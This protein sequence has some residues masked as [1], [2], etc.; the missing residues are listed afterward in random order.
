VKR[1]THFLSNY[2]EIVPDEVEDGVTNKS[3]FHNLPAHFRVESFNL[4]L[5]QLSICVAG[6]KN[7][8]FQLMNNLSTDEID[9]LRS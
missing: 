2:W 8:R 9:A 7:G 3:G 5:W 4:R 6:F 1:L